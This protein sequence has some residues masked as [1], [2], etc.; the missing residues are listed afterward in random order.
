MCDLYMNWKGIITWNSR[1]RDLGSRREGEAEVYSWKVG[2]G[3]KEGRGEGSREGGGWPNTR[4][5][6]SSYSIQFGYTPNVHQHI[7]D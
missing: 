4:M 6:C 3:G 5:Q 7:Q 1:Y 2:G